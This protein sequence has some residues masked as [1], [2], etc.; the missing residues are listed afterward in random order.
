LGEGPNMIRRGPARQWGS[1]EWVSEG[2]PANS[3]I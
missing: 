2:I 1:R 3:S